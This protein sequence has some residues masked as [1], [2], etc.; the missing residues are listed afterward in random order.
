MNSNKHEIFSHNWVAMIKLII[1]ILSVLGLAASGYCS[2]NKKG[3]GLDT[4]GRLFVDGKHEYPVGIFVGWAPAYFA[5]NPEKR[6]QIISELNDIKNSPFRIVVNYGSPTG[7]PAQAKKLL[8]ELYKRGIYDIFSI[9]DYFPNSGLDV[10]KNYALD[11]ETLS[12]TQNIEETVVRTVVRAVKDHPAVLGWYLC[13]E[14][15]DAVPVLEHY[16][17]VKQEDSKHPVLP[18]TNHRTAE[19]IRPFV[20]TGDIVFI[21]DYPVPD[22]PVTQVANTMDE[23]V[24]AT[25]GKHPAWFAVQTEGNYVYHTGVR[26][27]GEKLPPSEISG[28]HRLA[29]PREMR[30]MSYL[31]LIHGAKGLVYYYYADIKLAFDS[32]MRWSVVKSMAQEIRDLSPVLLASDVDKDKIKG[33]NPAVHFMAKQNDGKTY[34]IAVNG[35]KEVQSTI[36]TLP[37]TVKKAN[38]LTGVGTAYP[39]N[40]ELLLT[41]DGYEAVAVELIH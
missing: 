23:V 41:L 28:R 32:E 31:A 39:W 29:T 2:T 38:L 17:W 35:L 4:S 27:H 16:R 18:L 36:I 37:S 11:P 12:K 30:A 14:E 19:K 25:R 22:N 26:E 33:N 8:D 10:F 3:V 21:D 7:T 1:L 13:D 20:S 24:K 34:I 5:E 6:K 15:P 40:N 9:K